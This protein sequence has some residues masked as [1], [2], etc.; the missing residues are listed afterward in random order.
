MREGYVLGM[1]LQP[2]LL[3]IPEAV[4]KMH[5]RRQVQD[6]AL[7]EK[8]TPRYAIGC[9]RILL[10]EDWYPTITAPNAELVT[11]RIERVEGNAIVTADGA[12]RELDTIILATGFHPTDPPIARRLRGADGRTLSETWQGSPQAY[13]GT[14]VAGFPNLFLL[15]GPNLNLGHSSIVYMLESQVRY[16]MKALRAMGEGTLEVRGEVQEEWNAYLQERLVGTVWDKGGCSS[17]YLDANGRDSVMWPDFT[18]RYRHR[19]SEFD[20]AEY[21]VG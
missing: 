9:K 4:A 21:I 7:R 2:R 3:K 1:V 20:P 8:L 10:S 12:R 13:V 18:F 14:T 19:V 6:P 17:W 11:D 15:Y 16:V 5:M